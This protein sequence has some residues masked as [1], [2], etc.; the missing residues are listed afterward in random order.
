LRQGR[1][2]NDAL[3][4][5]CGIGVRQRLVLVDDIVD[6]VVHVIVEQGATVVAE[7]ACIEYCDA[8][9]VEVF[10]SIIAGE[11]L[12]VRPFAVDGDDDGALEAREGWRSLSR[13]PECSL[14]V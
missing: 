8:L 1:G 11:K 10:G 6:G 4:R 13:S 5:V 9:L 3:V 2:A 7:I 14:G 12:P